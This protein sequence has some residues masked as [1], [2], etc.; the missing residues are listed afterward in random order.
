M[1]NPYS[2]KGATTTH[3]HTR[4]NKFLIAVFQ[5]TQHFTVGFWLVGSRAS[6]FRSLVDLQEDGKEDLSAQAAQALAVAGAESALVCRFAVLW[7]GF[8]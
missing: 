3:M 4:T 6:A 8:D 1:S 5:H 2:A 7:R